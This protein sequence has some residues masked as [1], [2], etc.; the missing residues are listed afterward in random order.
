MKTQK[1]NH[2]NENTQQWFLCDSCKRNKNVWISKYHAC[3]G[4]FIDFGSSQNKYGLAN[5]RSEERK[6]RILHK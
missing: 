2:K 4:E 6:I 1:T 3:S 5:S